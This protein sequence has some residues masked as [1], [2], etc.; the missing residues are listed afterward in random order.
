MATK[1]RPVPKSKPSKATAKSSAAKSSARKAAAPK[2]APVKGKAA[3]AAAPKSAPAKG[4]AGKAAKAPTEV[5]ATAAPKNG[6]K[7]PTAAQRPAIAQP[8]EPVEQ[9]EAELSLMQLA[10]RAALKRLLRN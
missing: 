5:K 7:K 1:K 6:V 10:K 2:S 3:K 9:N 8:S 4:K